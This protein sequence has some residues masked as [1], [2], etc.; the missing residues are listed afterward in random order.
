[1]TIRLR[2]KRLLTPP[3]A[4][5]A[6]LVILIEEYLWDGLQA[7]VERI[8]RAPAIWRLDARIASLPPYPAMT[9]FLVPAVTLIPVKLFCA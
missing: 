3:L 1:V 5:L 4:V 2:T 8:A 6:A 9:L 7:L